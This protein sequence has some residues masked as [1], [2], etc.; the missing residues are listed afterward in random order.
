[1]NTPAALLYV[2]L[3][4]FKQ[5]NDS[6]G[7]AA[8]DTVLVAAVM[9]LKRHTRESDVVGRIGGDEFAILMWN[10]GAADAEAKALVLEAAIARTTAPYRDTVLSVTASVGA[11][12]LLPLDRPSD[13]LDRADRAMYARKRFVGRSA[14][15]G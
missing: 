2:D 8:G 12:V 10:C 4:R 5:I 9:V 7:H 1:H 11:T 6:H 3:D 14:D 15:T 13:A